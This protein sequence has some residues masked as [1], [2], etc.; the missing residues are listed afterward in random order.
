METLS[1]ILLAGLA[2]VLVVFLGMWLT[3]WRQT[4]PCPVWLAWLVEMEN[5]FTRASRAAVIIEQLGVKPGMA[6]L[7]AGC[8]P[9]RV[10]IPVARQVGAGG[11]VVALDMQTGMLERVRAKAAAENLTQVELLQAALGEGKLGSQKFDRALLVTVLGEVPDRHAALKE[12]Y[13][14][15]RPGG[16]LAVTEVILDP[17]F[18]R[19]RTVTQWTQAVG[20]RTKATHGHGLAYTMI[21]ERPLEGAAES[22]PL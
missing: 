19:Q 11:R 10:T 3:S 6:V 15:L 14:A 9:G 2:L 21:L 8:G 16:L 17:H 4:L 13:E 12:I 22:Q 20:F 5:P 18:Q 1:Y 7:D